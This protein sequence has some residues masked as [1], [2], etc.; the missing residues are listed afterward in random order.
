MARSHNVR[1]IPKPHSQ[2]DL[3]KLARTLLRLAEVTSPGPTK[4]VTGTKPRKDAA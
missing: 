1:I 4:P 2:P 3:R